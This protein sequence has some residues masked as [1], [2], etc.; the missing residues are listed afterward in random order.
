VCARHGFKFVFDQPCLQDT[1]P[2]R[3]TCVNGTI[4]GASLV[5]K[6]HGMCSVMTYISLPYLD[7]HCSMRRYGSVEVMKIEKVNC[8][9]LQL[10]VTVAL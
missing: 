6:T 4:R 3:W 7:P 1:L 9:T 2:K 8:G 10:E 5:C